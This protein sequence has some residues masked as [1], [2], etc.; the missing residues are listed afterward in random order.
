MASGIG[1]I[2][3]GLIFV[4]RDTVRGLTTA[5]SVWVSAAIGLACGAGAP[6][7]GSTGLL[8]ELCVTFLLPKVRGLQPIQHKSY[9]LSVVYPTGIGALRDIISA[10]SS[11][12]W[13]VEEFAQFRQSTW[14]LTGLVTHISWPIV[15]KQFRTFEALRSHLLQPKYDQI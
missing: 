1:F 6:E 7:L 12:G 4:R 5:A 15:S 10:C 14:R 11:A 3:G 2:D 9:R 8:L 13:T